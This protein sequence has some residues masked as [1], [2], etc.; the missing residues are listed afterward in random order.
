M[1]PLL[2][3]ATL[4]VLGGGCL[5]QPDQTDVFVSRQEGYHTFR[6]PAAIVTPKG[7]VL[8]FCEGRRNSASDT[9][10]IDLLLKRSFDGGKTWGPLQ[11]VAEDGPNTVGN[12]CPVIDRDTGTIWLPL[13]HNLGEDPESRIID[14]I[15]TGTRRVW[16]TK[17]DDD[18]AT[19]AAPV[20]ITDQTKAPNWTWYATGPGVGIQ[21]RSGRMV[22]PCDHMVAVTK[23][24]RSHV[25]FSDDQGQT[26]RIGGSVGPGLNECQVVELTDGSLLLNMRNY[27]KSETNRR[28]VARSTDGGLTWSAPSYDA[29][30]V[31]PICQASSLRYDA[32][33]LLFSNPASTK[34][35]QMTVRLSLDDGQIWPSRLVLHWGPAAY[36]CLTVLPD[37]LIGCLYECGDAHPYERIR[38]ARVSPDLLQ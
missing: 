12:P 23:E 38:F 2:I 4:V 37:G 30:L 10:D 20:D 9:G 35:E 14:Q 1:D 24:Y 25:I 26:W 8:A 6:I 13:T 31:E 7:T 27:H 11:L 29:A 16:L 36:S 18:G 19:W 17:S 33:R 3:A 21:L 15:S 5:M 22:I 34:R 32:G 28:A